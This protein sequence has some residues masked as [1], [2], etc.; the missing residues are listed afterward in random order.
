MLRTEVE[1]QPETALVE[2]FVAPAWLRPRCRPVCRHRRRGAPGLTALMV[3]TGPLSR[4]GGLQ[5]RIRMTLGPPPSTGSC[6]PAPTRPAIGGAG[7]LA[8]AG[9]EPTASWLRV[10]AW[11]PVLTAP[12]LA[13]FA[14]L[15]DILRRR[16]PAEPS[17]AES[18]KLA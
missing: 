12:T 7:V 1:E 3:D 10:W 6:R 13:G 15:L 2:F 18:C 16:G 4:T 17:P 8:G 9:E 5:Q 11:S 14:P